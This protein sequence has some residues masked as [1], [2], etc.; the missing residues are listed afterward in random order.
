MADTFLLEV[1]NP[2]KLLLSENVE[3]MTA[4]GSEGEFGVLPGHAHMLTSLKTGELTY[5]KGKE[6]HRIPI[7]WGYVE[8]GPEK[9]IALVETPSL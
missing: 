5:R 1:V 3:E 6:V 4:P 8:V 9:V 7:N 2:Y